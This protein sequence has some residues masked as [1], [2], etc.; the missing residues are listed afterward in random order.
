[1]KRNVVRC[2]L[3]AMLVAIVGTAKAQVLPQGLG[4]QIGFAEPILRL[5][6]DN[7]SY[8]ADS[9]ANTVKLNGMKIGLVYDVSY[10]KGFGSSIGVN[11]TI[12]GGHTNWTQPNSLQ[13]CYQ[14]RTKSVYQEME[15]FVDWQYKFEI[16]KQTYIIL[17]S[18]PTIQ[19]G[20]SYSQRTYEKEW[21]EVTKVDA[22]SRYNYKDEDKMCDLKRLNVTWG[23]G[24]GFQ[25]QRY[26]LR[27][28]YDFGLINP[29]KNKNFNEMGGT[30]GGTGIDRYTRGR[31]DQWNI[32][33]GVY[34]W[35]R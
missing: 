33:L 27:G 30:G 4:V 21:K 10:I 17:Y 28:G 16:A 11:Y 35:Q 7:S 12:A 20:L 31:L 3:A 18:G 26:F 1:M 2:V 23:V 15:L 34:L 5:N 24:A 29:Y 14:T 6:T 9:L 22:I 13:S 32:R 8:K 25:Y 19:W